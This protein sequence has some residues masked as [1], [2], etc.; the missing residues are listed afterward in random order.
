MPGI[1]AT[2]SF[3]N[4]TSPVNRGVW[5]LE[6]ILGQHVPPPPANVP[7]LEK[8][9]HEKITGLTLRQRT[10]LH[11]KDPTCASC[12][13]VL[14]P[15]G[16]GLENFDAIGR[17]R[18]KDDSGGVIDA[19][20]E[21]PGDLRFSTPKEL[22]RIIAG[23][24]DEFVRNLTGA[25]WRT[26]SAAARRLRRDRGRA[27]GRAVAQDGY[28]MQT[29][30][31]AVA[32]ELPVHPSPDQ[33]AERAHELRNRLIDRRTLLRGAWRG[34]RLPL[35]RDHGLGRGKTGKPPVRLAFMFMPHAS[36]WSAS[37]R[38]PGDVPQDAPADPRAPQGVLDQCSREGRERACPSQPL[39]GAPHALE[40][41]TWLT[42]T[43]PDTTRR[44]VIN[45][46]ISADQIRRTTSAPSRRSVAGAGDDAAD[47]EGEPGGAARGVLLAL[48][49]RVAD[50]AA[51]RRDRPARRLQAAL[52]D[53]GSDRRRIAPGSAATRSTGACSTSCWAARRTC[54]GS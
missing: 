36:S 9:D 32:H 37:G 34:A 26:R 44:D 43:L 8:Q 39:N 51:A 53:E 47:L 42:A 35:L 33:R 14:D 17:W 28:R 13:K 54:A 20:G 40:L 31:V 3:P 15:I 27:D 48:Q 7:P 46:A 4:R 5:V 6:Q 45:I 22:K 24:L 49:L 16:F 41:S 29:L 25:C 50:P 11:R 12:H 18:V 38:R 21:L 30:V 10:E 2:T 23:R 19:S 52:P 1:L